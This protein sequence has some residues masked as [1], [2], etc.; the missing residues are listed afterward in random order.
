MSRRRPE[1]VVA[2]GFALFLVAWALLHQGWY[3]R[4]QIVDLPV[5]ERYGNAIERGEVPYRDFAVEYPPLALPVFAAPSLLS[6]DSDGYRAVFEALMA[7]SGA[8]LAGLVALVTRSYAATAAAALAPLAL[9][10][11]VLS[12][13]DLWPALLTAAALAALLAGRDRLGFLALGLGVAAKLYPGVLLPLAAAHVW[14]RRGRREALLGLGVAAAVV[15]AAYLPFVLVAPEGVASS[16]GRQLS[17]PLQIESLGAAVFL[18]AHQVAGVSLTM[19]PGHGSQNLGGTGP[20]VAALL[21]SSVQV[22]LLAWLWARFARRGGDLAVACAAAVA[23]F[24]A[25]GKVLSPQFLLWLVPLVPLVR[26]R[27]AW[28]LLV[29]AL[30]LTQLWFPYR[31]WELARA[32]AALPSWLVVARDLV[33]VALAAYLLRESRR[34]PARSA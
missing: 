29:A 30:V 3:A 16:V 19:Q 33:L 4:D 5:Y 32:F 11:V 23:V 18:A 13:F 24:V 31:Y 17:R 12:R 28:A 2:A 27:A 34:A 14:R 8:A 1:P 22:A 7:A 20:A 25:F 26:A 15:G 21:S 10:S 6:G 9:G